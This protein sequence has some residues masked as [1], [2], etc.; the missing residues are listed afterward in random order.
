MK[1]TMQE[2][3]AWGFLF[4]QFSDL[5]TLDTCHAIKEKIKLTK[6]EMLSVDFSVVEDGR[7]WF[8]D[9][10]EGPPKEVVFEDAEIYLMQDLLREKINTKKVPVDART[11]CHKIQELV[12]KETRPEQKR[13]KPK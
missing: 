3:L 4:P 11:V 1:Y 7:V 13:P 12:P 5:L 8:D 6:E 9:K 10:K 2:R